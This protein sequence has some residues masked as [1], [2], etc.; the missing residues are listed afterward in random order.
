METKRES[1]TINY[2]Q[3]FLKRQITNDKEAMVIAK[4]LPALQK[5]YE[6]GEITKQK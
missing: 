2:R 5:E 6:N 3:V 1:E 4:K